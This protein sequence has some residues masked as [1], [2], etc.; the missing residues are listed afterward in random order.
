[1][2]SVSAA[3]AGQGTLGVELNKLEPVENGCR[4]YFV[5]DNGTRSAFDE[6][7]LDLVMFGTGGLI[8][9]RLTVDVGRLPAE[10]RRSGCSTCKQLPCSELGQILLNEVLACRDQSGMRSDCT[11]FVQ[12]CSGSTVAF[13]K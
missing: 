5:F 3:S 7:R 12:P 8:A 9:T 6:L 13:A 1:V 2:L 10:R 11:S 4:A